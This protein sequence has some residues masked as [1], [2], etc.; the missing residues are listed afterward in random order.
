MA[1][2]INSNRNTY[3][4]IDGSAVQHYKRFKVA[5]KGLSRASLGCLMSF[6]ALKFTE[7]YYYFSDFCIEN[8]AKVSCHWYP[9]FRQ[10]LSARDENS[11]AESTLVQNIS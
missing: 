10:T 7:V 8:N 2:W 9:T 3:S 5:F 6:I 1:N 4:Q 11:T